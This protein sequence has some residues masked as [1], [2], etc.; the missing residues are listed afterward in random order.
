MVALSLAVVS[1]A[2]AQLVVHVEH[3]STE[4]GIVG[5]DI[6]GSVVKYPTIR[7]R[8]APAPILSAGDSVCVH[9]TNAHPVFYA[10]ALDV[11]VDTSSERLPDVGG[12][13]ALL[14]E[15]LAPRSGQSVREV[16][17]GSQGYVA[18]FFKLFRVLDSA[19]VAVK[20]KVLASDTAGIGYA[21]SAVAGLPASPTTA[22]LDAWVKTTPDPKDDVAM[23]VAALRAYGAALL[24]TREAL[25]AS[26]PRSLSSTLIRCGA[27]GKNKTTFRLN[28]KKKSDI[29]SRPARDGIATV[30]VTPRFERAWVE[31]LPVLLVAHVRNVPAF[32]LDASGVVRRTTAGDE[33]RYRPGAAILLNLVRRDMTAG[34]FVGFGVS[35]DQNP[36]LSDF[37]VGVLVSYKDY[38]RIG[39]AFGQTQS[40]TGI[41]PPAVVDQVLPSGVALDELIDR[42]DKSAWYITIALPKLG[43][44]SPW[45]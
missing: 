3:Q 42:G 21:T 17:D 45:P 18:E 22:E 29:G 16:V 6:G 9:V 1:R 5:Y 32:S 34:P 43:L 14:A 13:V 15:A 27:V 4:A 28:I 7:P 30:E 35:D 23:I 37:L 39:V 40:V 10:Y 33:K 24:A 36:S 12:A 25:K 41:K 8:L 2:D 38:I 31:A 19:V 20:A 11:A 26:Y 44:K